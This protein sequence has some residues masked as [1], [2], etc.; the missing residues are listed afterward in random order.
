VNMQIAAAEIKNSENELA[1]IHM[2]KRRGRV[3]EFL[4]I[5]GG[6]KRRLNGHGISA[7][8]I[9]K[10]GPLP[11]TMRSDAKRIKKWDLRETSIQG[12]KL[13]AW[14]L[15]DDQNTRMPWRSESMIGKSTRR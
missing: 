12:G 10:I 7:A 3:H 11:L 9:A 8:G 13:E 2:E 6:T 15:Y 5:I 14:T 4:R 1:P